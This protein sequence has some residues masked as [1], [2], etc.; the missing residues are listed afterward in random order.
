MRNDQ[1]I[2]LH[3][4]PAKALFGQEERHRSHGC[5]RVQDALGF[6]RMIADQQ[7]RLDEW[8]RALATGEETFVT[9]PAEIGVRLLYHTAF[10]DGGRLR[11]RPDAY[12]WDDQVAEALGLP[13]RPRRTRPSH[14]SDVGP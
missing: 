7:G 6:A 13:A 9:L 12:G 1:S 4:T 3:D 10:L 8:E 11:F 5:V 2:Y 14:L